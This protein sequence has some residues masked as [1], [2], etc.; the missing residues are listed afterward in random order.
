MKRSDRLA[1]AMIATV[2]VGGMAAVDRVVAQAT[3]ADT[4]A[5]IEFQRT[6][7]AYAFMHRQLERR[8]GMAHR[9]SGEPVDVV[10]ADVRR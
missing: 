2:I 8:V 4:R 3:F 6:A 5:V 1:A 10:A 9:R 7:D